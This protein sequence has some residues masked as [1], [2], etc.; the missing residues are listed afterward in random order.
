VQEKTSA[1]NTANRSGPVWQRLRPALLVI[2]LF[3]SMPL[4]RAT[5]ANVAVACGAV[6]VEFELCRQVRK[7]GLRA[8]AMSSV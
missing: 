6:G 3:C 7:G 4:N 8:P 1:L 2:A 5:A